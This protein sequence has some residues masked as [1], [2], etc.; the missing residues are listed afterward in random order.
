MYN[1]KGYRNHKQAIKTTIE[2]Y[3]AACIFSIDS[4]KDKIKETNL[5]IYGAENVFASKQIQ[6]KIKQT[7]LERYGVEN[8]LA[9]PEFREKAKQTMLERYGVD[10]VS[11]SI[12]FRRKSMTNYTY[13]GISFDSMPELA[14]YVY[15]TDNNI[16]FEYQPD[17]N[18]LYTVDGKV[19][20]YYPDFTVEGKVWKIKGKHF[21][22]E[23]GTWQNPWNHEFDYCVE[24]KHQC[25][26]ENNV[27]VITDYS[28]YIDYVAEKYGK[29][30]L[31]QFKNH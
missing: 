22:K 13:N 15:L 3:G 27:I 24:A 14:V 8:V 28:M 12:E 21:I 16:E 23:D 5:K 19:H 11:K 6:E 18:Y 26:I 17:L 2:R 31:Q 9:S 25:I 29:S 1:D 10:H 7:T 20:H 4:F 30:Y